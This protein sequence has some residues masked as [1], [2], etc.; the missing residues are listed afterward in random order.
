[1]QFELTEALI[2]E[3]LFSME[4][5]NG[6]FCVDTGEGIVISEDDEQFD[7]QSPDGRIISLPE[8]DSS[9]GFRLMERFAA[10]F[11][12]AVIRNRLTAALDRGHGVFRAFKDVLSGYPEAEQLWY[13]YKEK[14]MRRIIMDWYNGLREEWGLERIGTEPEETGDLVL[15]DF[16]FRDASPEDRNTAEAIHRGCIEELHGSLRQRFQDKI[17]RSFIEEWIGNWVFPG[18]MAIMAETG[19]GEFAAYITA[20]IRGDALRI[21]ALEVRPEYR[22][23]GIGE[24]LLSRLLERVKSGNLSRIILELPAEADA[25]SRVLLR[26]SFNPY[27]TGYVKYV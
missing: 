5:Q 3:I 19:S 14:K 2:D 18:D 8:W 9:E 13:A 1:M 10:G 6:I 20:L 11:K 16:R 7:S 26:N 24:A 4:D 17:P 23:L 22:G 15:E 12:N 25:F 27:T 21:T